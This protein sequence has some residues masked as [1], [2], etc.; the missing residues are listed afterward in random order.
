VLGRSS[1]ALADAVSSRVGINSLSPVLREIKDEM[2]PDTECPGRAVT[3]LDVSLETRDNGLG[4]YSN[5]SE[6]PTLVRGVGFEACAGSTSSAAGSLSRSTESSE[7][8]EVT[9]SVRVGLGA[10]PENSGV[11]SL[12]ARAGLLGA[13]PPLS[14][15]LDGGRMI[16]DRSWLE[17][18]ADLRWA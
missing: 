15:W 2:L 18:A 13:L 17:I 12:L 5:V 10:A 3:V 8:G 7:E 6:N 9:G 11:F 4:M 14:F 1:S 16:D